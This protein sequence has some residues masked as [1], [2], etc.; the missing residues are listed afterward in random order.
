MI[1]YACNAP[2]Y[3]RP[4]GTVTLIVLN[5]VAYL[6]AVFGRIDVNDGWLLQ[7]GAGVHP[8]EWVLSIFMHGDPAHLIGNMIFLW[9]FGLV[10]EGR[11]GLARFLACYLAIGVGQ[12]AIEQF[13]MS[14]YNGDSPG[15]MGASSA[16]YGLMAMACVWAPMNEVSVLWFTFIRFYPITLTFEITIGVLSAFY[17][18]YEILLLLITGGQAGSSWLHLGGVLMGLPLGVVLLKTGVVD[19]EDWDLFAV[20]S[21]CYGAD[22]KEAREKAGPDPA[23]LAAR[24]NA[25]LVEAERKFDAYLQINQPDK[26]LAL[27]RRMLD[28]SN[29]LTLNK[30]DLLR[31]IT[32]LHQQKLWIDSAPLM[33]EFL[34]SDPEAAAGM[35]LKLA[36]ICLVAMQRPHKSLEVLAP[37]NGVGLTTAESTLK[38]KIELAAERQI[39]AGAL[40]VDDSAW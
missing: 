39:A 17:V 26:A 7:W 29:P 24:A 35:R 13:V 22:A 27:R 11:V 10:T 25:K 33:A 19:G 8:L 40:E 18:G 30:Q 34:D 28:L 14:W 21:G 15:S 9:V 3:H 20:M 6:A 36:Q 12:S 38:K 16:I 2:L 4:F 1:P 32:K 37:L 23:K 31:L 5:V